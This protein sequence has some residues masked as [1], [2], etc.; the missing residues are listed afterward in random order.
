MKLAPTRALLATVLS[1]WLTTSAWAGFD[2]GWAAYQRGDYATA[3][4]EW[5]P[6]AIG[7]D[8][9]AQFNLGLM[10]GGGYGVASN[11]VEAIKWYRLAAEQGFAKAQAKLGHF[12]YGGF[13]S[14]SVEAVQWFRKAAEQDEPTAYLGLGYA[15][16]TGLGVSKDKIQAAKWLRLAAEGGEPEA[17]MSLGVM[18]SRGDGVLQ[19]YVQAHMWSNLAAAQGHEDGRTY[20]DGIAALMTPADISEAQRLAR[21]WLEQHGE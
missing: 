1:L 15:Y 18:Y 9:N 6:L 10:Y 5:L 20:R 7:G 12:L 11:R 17:M 21:E 19:D 16:S 4:D 13:G 3:H 14:T 2:E 8:A